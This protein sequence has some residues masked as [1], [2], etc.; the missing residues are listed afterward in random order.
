MPMI[1]WKNR[2]GADSTTKQRRALLRSKAKKV[3]I[4]GR[5]GTV[6]SV[7]VRELP[8]RSR[9][10]LTVFRDEFDLRRHNGVKA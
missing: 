2:L 1:W 5:N 10:V 7:M 6:G 3:W 4:A 8:D 9:V